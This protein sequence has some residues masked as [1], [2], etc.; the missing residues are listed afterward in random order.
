M[1]AV[2]VSANKTSNID[3]GTKKIYKYPLPTRVFDIGKMVVDGRHPEDPKKVILERD[4]S[5][6]MYVTKGKGKYIVSGDEIK[7]EAGDVVYVPT[8]NT[9]AC[10]GKFEYV[11]VDIPAYYPEQ[12]EEV[13]EK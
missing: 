10:E 5:F 7:V 2:K 11:T 9:F 4:C 6:V 1:K 12:S 3:L 13:K 8:G